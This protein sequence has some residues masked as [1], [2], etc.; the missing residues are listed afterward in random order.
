MSDVKCQRKGKGALKLQYVVS[1]VTV[2]KVVTL[3]LERNMEKN[4]PYHLILYKTKM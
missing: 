4:F 3:H 2:I 1:E